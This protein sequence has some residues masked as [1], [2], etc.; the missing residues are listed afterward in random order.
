MFAHLPL[1]LGKDRK[2]LSKRSGDTALGDYVDAGYPKEAIVNFLC[3]QGWALDGET[4]VFD[5]ETFVE[6]FDVRNVQK[7]GAVFDIDKFRWLS[8]DAIRRMGVTE[9]SDALVPF[10]EKAGL[11]TSAEVSE[12]RD[13]FEALVR[14]EQARIE[15]YSEFPPRVKPLFEP[16]DAVTYEEKAEKG[17]RKHE[18]RVETLRAFAEW[19]TGRD[20]IDDPESLGAAGKA[21]VKEREIKFPALFQPLRCALLGQQGGRD[22]FDTIRLLGPES[23]QRRIAAAAERLG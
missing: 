10:A 1:M 13:W 20:D 2:K 15:T 17:A 23:V 7:A 5:L 6:N 21:W 18:A 12:R 11:M 19:I 9:L 14:G 4:E 16:D 8:G 22:L 3:L